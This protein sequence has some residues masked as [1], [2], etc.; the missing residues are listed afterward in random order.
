MELSGF[1]TSKKV[2]VTSLRSAFSMARIFKYCIAV[3][4][5]HRAVSHLHCANFS[6]H[7]G[8]Q[9]RGRC[10]KNWEDKMYVSTRAEGRQKVIQPRSTLL[11][12][13]HCDYQPTR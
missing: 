7:F 6:C 8:G 2:D 1:R 13:S 9:G 4:L 10:V 12:V 3:C 11:S 5:I